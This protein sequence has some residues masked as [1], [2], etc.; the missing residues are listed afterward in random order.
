MMLDF[1]F[2]EL[3]SKFQ[4]ERAPDAVE[5]RECTVFPGPSLVLW[6]CWLITC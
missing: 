5:N 1:G 6:R 3:V 4:W 2:Q